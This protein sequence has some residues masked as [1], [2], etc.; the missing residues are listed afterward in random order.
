MARK[1]WTAQTDITPFL[2]QFREKR[3]W[4]I[5]LRRYVLEQKWSAAYAPY[6][7]I[8]IPRFRQWIET[9][10]EPGMGWT[11]FSATWQLDHIVPVAYFDF[12][13]DADLRLCWHFTNIR[14]EK[15]GLIGSQID[16]IGAKTY[17]A[18]LYD[19][20]NHLLCRNMVAKLDL[21]DRQQQTS[22][23][24]SLSFFQANA[25]Y[26]NLIADFTDYEYLRLNEGVDVH[27]ILEERATLKS[28]H[29]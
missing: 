24:A 11:Q 13:Q 28:L 18:A 3:K 20:T 19:Q 25:S 16:L 5:A 21:L 15:V 17:F 9:Q 22:R 27:K 26:L 10:F 1:K 29:N 2:L 6:F 4:Q 12:N 7:G 14:V 23:G 8:D